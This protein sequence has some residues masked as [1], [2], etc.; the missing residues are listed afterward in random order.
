MN[1]QSSSGRRRFWQ[2]S[3]RELLALFAVLGILLSLLA[4]RL[5]RAFEEWE[6]RRTRRVAQVAQKVLSRAIRE[7]DANLAR[8][9]LEAGADPTCIDSPESSL[10]HTCIE[11]GQC[12]LAKVLLDHGADVE[13]TVRLS[14]TVVLSGPALFAAVAC[15]QPAETRLRMVQML[16]AHGADVRREIGDHNLVD[17]AVHNGDAQMADFLR[18]CGVSY[19]PAEM[20]AFNRLDELKRAVDASPNIVHER[21]RPIYAAKPGHGPTLL[22]IALSKGHR[23]MALFL[24][25]RRAPLDTLEYLGQTLLHRAARGGD[26]ELI[27][28]LVARGLDVNARDAYQDTPLRDMMG[29]GK[30][31]A[32]EALIEAGANVNAVGMN[33]YTPLLTAVYYNHVSIVEMLLEAGADP[34]IPN[35]D[36][37]TALDLARKKHP[38]LLKL[39]EKAGS[40]SHSSGRE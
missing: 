27:R 13:R 6:L 35:R 31:E 11:R 28:L 17:I 20:A 25:E 7:N 23:E 36:G 15:D 16:I 29:K 3:L 38:E 19:G 9:A 8:Q 2:F 22:G 21:F 18:Q 32:V 4:P 26:P 14:D 5:H 39:L 37:E 10:L 40:R 1:T 30:P 33:G 34:T 12:E 24:I